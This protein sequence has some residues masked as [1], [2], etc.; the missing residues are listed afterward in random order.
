MEVKYQRDSAVALTSEKSQLSRLDRLV[1]EKATRSWLSKSTGL[2]A[3][4]QEGTE[5]EYRYSSTLS[6]TSALDGDEW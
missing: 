4:C 6:L 5:S 3:T 1:V 2:P